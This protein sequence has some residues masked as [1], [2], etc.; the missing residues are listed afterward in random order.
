MKAMGATFSG[1][2]GT[3]FTNNGNDKYVAIWHTFD[4][5]ILIPGGTPLKDLYDDYWTKTGNT[6]RPIL[7][8]LDKAFQM[9]DCIGAMDILCSD[10]YTDLPTVGRNRNVL[11][12]FILASK[13]ARTRDGTAAKK[14]IA[15]V[16]WGYYNPYIQS[17][18]DFEEDH[19]VVKAYSSNA[20]DIIGMFT[21]CFGGDNDY[22]R[23][24]NQTGGSSLWT[25]I[26][27]E[28]TSR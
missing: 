24:Y 22:K 21:Y 13:A 27:E 4:E 23:L 12:D 19:E 15:I 20:V 8:N 26:A 17:S 5:P 9:E 14:K 10:P 2:M 28:N 18:G 3:H 1:S 11:K 25:K 16:L 7:I 6:E